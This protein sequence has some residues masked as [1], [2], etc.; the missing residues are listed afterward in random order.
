MTSTSG[1]FIVDEPIKVNG[2]ND[3]KTIV[4]V[5]ESSLDDI[6]SIYQQV[7]G[8]TFNADAV[9]SREGS[10]A[11]AGTEYTNTTGGTCTVA[12]NRFTSII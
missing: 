11:P 8:S 7:S 6:K 2:V 4:T 10:P 5:T 3:T 9:L 12:G 1:N